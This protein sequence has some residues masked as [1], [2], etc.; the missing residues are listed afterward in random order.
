MR[1]C[2]AGITVGSTI[3]WAGAITVG[4][5]D[6]L[7]DRQLPAMMVLLSL[8]IFCSGA[9]VT[10]CQQ[11]PVAQAYELGYNAGRRDAI[12]DATKASYAMD[13][14]PIKRVRNPRPVRDRTL[15]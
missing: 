6:L 7:D 14:T 11:R 13:V 3:G 2:R 8:A 15:V 4:V 10:R 12:R 9:L 5:A 1:L